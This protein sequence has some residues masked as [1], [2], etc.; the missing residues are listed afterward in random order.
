MP[1][2]S[3]LQVLPLL[4]KE[5]PRAKVIMASSLTREGSSATLDALALGA[6]DFLTKPKGIQDPKVIEEVTRDLIDKVLTL[7][8]KPAQAKKAE[9]IAPSIKVKGLYPKLLILGSSTGGPNAL[10]VFLRV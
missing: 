9:A 5:K 4:L 7:G 1:G 6:T 2:L 10:S 3:G 8:K